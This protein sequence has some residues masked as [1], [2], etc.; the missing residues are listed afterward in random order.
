[1]SPFEIS[2]VPGFPASRKARSTGPR[3]KSR[4]NNMKQTAASSKR[5]LMVVGTLAT[6]ITLYGGYTL[7][8]MLSAILELP[9]IAL[10]FYLRWRA[11]TKEGS[12]R[13]STE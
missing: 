7:H 6:L 8:K 1:M 11:V 9:V 2:W 12:N 3:K 4:L 5:T 10:V 13:D